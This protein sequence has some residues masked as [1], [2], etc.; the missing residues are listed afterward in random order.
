MLHDNPSTDVPVESQQKAIVEV[1]HFVDSGNAPENEDV[2]IQDAPIAEE[3]HIQHSP[4]VVQPPQ[5]PIAV[6]KAKRAIRRTRRLIEECDF[7]AY[8]LSM[9]EE[10]EGNA[11][12]SSYYEAIISVDCNN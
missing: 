2:D 10:I 4:I 3:P 12:P 6:E 9:A 7:V 11:E 5:Q 1:E 8:A